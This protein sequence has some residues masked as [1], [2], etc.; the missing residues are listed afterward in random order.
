VT[1]GFNEHRLSVNDV[2]KIYWYELNGV[3]ACVNGVLRIYWYG[4]NAPRCVSRGV[5]IRVNSCVNSRVNIRVNSRANSRVN[6]RVNNR[7]TI[8]ISGCPEGTPPKGYKSGRPRTSAGWT[9]RLGRAG[10]SGKRICILCGACRAT[11][12]ICICAREK[13]ICRRNQSQSFAA[14]ACASRRGGFGV[15][16]HASVLARMR[17]RHSGV[18]RG[19]RALTRVSRGAAQM[20]DARAQRSRCCALF[21]LAAHGKRSQEVTRACA[22][23]R[24]RAGPSPVLRM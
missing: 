22:V 19:E 2:V 20:C 24:K 1:I 7:V 15:P 21:V 18:S 14:G 23:C 4:V 9:P 16:R 17:A 6:S 3:N 13:R 10:V 8:G 12:G 5:N 11:R